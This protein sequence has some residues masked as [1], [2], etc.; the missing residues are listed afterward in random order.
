MQITFC[1]HAESVANASERWQ[2]Q[3]D[4][5]LS[6]VGR[7]QAARL[8][9]RLREETFDLV[10]ASDLTRTVETA[11]AIGAPFER[12]PIWREIDV[13]AWEG[14]SRE[15]VLARYPSE[16]EA[17]MRGED[18]K[19]GG[20]ESWADVRARIASAFE[21]L[22]ARLEP[23]ANVLVVAHGG[24][25]HALVAHVFGFARRK[26]RPIGRI[27]NTALSTLTIDSRGPRLR[28]YNDASHLGGLGG[29]AKER[30][31]LG[32]PVVTAIGHD[33]DG[34]ATRPDPLA[35][36]VEWYDRLEHL[37]DTGAPHLAEMR[38]T[39]ARAFGLEENPSEDL[40]A[41]LAAVL[42]ALRSRHGGRRV[43]LLAEC[44]AIAGF[45]HATLV[46]ATDDGPGGLGELTHGGLCH[47]VLTDR[48]PTIADYNVGTLF[49][50]LT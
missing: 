2:G 26:A 33:G 39:L 20:G 42:Q 45:A 19:V 43:G 23:D 29:Y 7:A 10:I 46:D 27:G 41:D 5:P 24:V 50:R 40:G 37:Y 25:I 38:G 14:L 6:E 22:V 28:V 16:V 44:E 35:R 4:S 49:R 48:G 36:L 12:D 18:V 47:L 13:G 17:L 15:E 3:S 8:G 31:E 32:D 21:R 1:R 34:G 9:A 11:T 30:F